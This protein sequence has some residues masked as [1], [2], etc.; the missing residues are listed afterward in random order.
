MHV[1][2]HVQFE[3]GQSLAVVGSDS[4][5]RSKEKMPDQKVA[6]ASL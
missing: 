4:S 2:L 5:D 1:V 6:L 3:L